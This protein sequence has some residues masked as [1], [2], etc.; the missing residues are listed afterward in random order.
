M[1]ILERLNRTSKHEVVFR[2]EGNTLADLKALLLAFQHSDNKQ[3]LHSRLQ[4]PTPAAVLAI[5]VTALF[6]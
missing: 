1:G 2:H 4:C 3:R 6:S 5:E